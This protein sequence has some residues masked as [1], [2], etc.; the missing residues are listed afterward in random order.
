DDSSPVY[1]PVGLKGF[2]WQTV[3]NF[4]ASGRADLEISNNGIDWFSVA[5]MSAAAMQV[6]ATQP[7]GIFIRVRT[8]GGVVGLDAFMRLSG[9]AC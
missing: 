6:L 3:G 7:G 2:S 5:S 9:S 4:G 1:V 8:S